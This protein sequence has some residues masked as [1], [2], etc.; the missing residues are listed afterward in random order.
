MLESTAASIETIAHRTGYED[1]GFFT[2]APT[3]DG[4]QTVVGGYSF[5]GKPSRNVTSNTVFAV[6]LRDGLPWNE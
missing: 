1:P 3:P 6:T 2:Y 5:Q 4:N